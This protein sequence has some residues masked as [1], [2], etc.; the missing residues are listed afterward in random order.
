M[1]GRYANEI[2]GDGPNLRCSCTNRC[3]SKRSQS[4]RIMGL[5]RLSRHSLCATSLGS[6]LAAFDNAYTG[7]DKTSRFRFGSSGGFIAIQTS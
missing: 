7:S 6:I 3:S 1:N 4:F 2:F 5:L